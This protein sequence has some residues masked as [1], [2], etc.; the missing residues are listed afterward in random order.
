MVTG[1]NTG[2]TERSRSGRK[3]LRTMTT[4]AERFTSDL[5]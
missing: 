2:I 4:V 5:R 3:A 1:F